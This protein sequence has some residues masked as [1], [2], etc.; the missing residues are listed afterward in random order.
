MHL[1]E[2]SRRLTPAPLGLALVHAMMLIDE[3][4]V[5][6][7]VRANIERECARCPVLYP[8]G[9]ALRVAGYPLRVI[10]DDVRSFHPGQVRAHRA[11][12][13]DFAVGPATRPPTK[14]FP[15]GQR[16]FREG[17]GA[18]DALLGGNLL[19]GAHAHHL[20]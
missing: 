14:I 17:G 13:R 20:S 15:G 10:A 11:R 4:L 5:L 19:L 6:P 12:R 16:D 3:G 8:K 18:R 1:D 2:S 9:R 7:C